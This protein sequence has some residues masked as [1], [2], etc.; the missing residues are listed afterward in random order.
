MHEILLRIH[1]SLG[2]DHMGL[3]MRTLSLASL[4]VTGISYYFITSL[5]KD[6][7]GLRISILSLASLLVSGIRYYVITTHAMYIRF[8]VSLGNDHMVLRMRT[9]SL[10]SLHNKYTQSTCVRYCVF[11]F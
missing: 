6:H 10:A 2:N 11:G 8:H 4:A 7:I 1:M 3:H 9:S 5:G